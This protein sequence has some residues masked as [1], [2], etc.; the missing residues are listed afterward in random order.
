[1]R[2]TQLCSILPKNFPSNCCINILDNG[3]LTNTEYKKKLEEIVRYHIIHDYN[4]DSVSVS[5]D[6]LVKTGLYFTVMFRIVD[7][8]TLDV[9]L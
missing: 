7:D 2:K 8:N 9:I 5:M 1:M 6:V 4:V 3:K